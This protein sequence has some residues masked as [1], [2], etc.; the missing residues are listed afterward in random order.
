M[1]QAGHVATKAYC[2][3]AFLAVTLLLAVIA[4][5]FVT[6]NAMAGLTGNY[7]RFA[8]CPYKDPKVSKCISSTTIGGEVVLGSTKVPIVNPTVLQG[9]YGPPNNKGV[10]KF[11][12]ATDGVTLSKASQPVPGGLLGLVPP[13]SASPLVKAVIALLFENNLLKVSASLELARPADEIRF[14]EENF[15]GEIGPAIVLPIRVHL[16]NPFLGS[17]CY[18]GSSSS[19]IAWALTSGATSPPKPNK[20]ITGTVGEVKFLAEGALAETKGTT[21]VDNAWSAPA[22]NGCGGSL[23]FLVNP[24]VNRSAGLPSPAGVSTVSLESTISI[25]SPPSV[26]ENAE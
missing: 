1:A 7:A 23:S 20:P 12:G 6:G 13:A 9:A 18:I 16:E 15:G 19:P 5:L 11:I 26:E 8:Q 21:L 3:K 22:A 25:A 17:S 2:M 14:S 24:I 10:S 4:S